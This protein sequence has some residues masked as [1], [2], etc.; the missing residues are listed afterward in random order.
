MCDGT[1]WILLGHALKRIVRSVVGK[2]MKE[3][4][5]PVEFLLDFRLARRWERYS[6]QLLRCRVVVLLLADGGHSRERESQNKRESYHCRLP[7]TQMIVRFP[8]FTPRQ[9]RCRNRL[10]NARNPE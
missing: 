3:S 6:P 9:I 7:D 5:G 10:L 4:N 1:L 2:G 8:D